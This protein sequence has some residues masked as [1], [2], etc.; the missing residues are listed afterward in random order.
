[1]TAVELVYFPVTGYLNAV[2][3]GVLAAINATVVFWPRV[4][5]GFTV[6]ISDLDLGSGDDQSAAVVFPPQSV[7]TIGGALSYSLLSNSSPIA[8]ALAAAVPPIAELIYDVEFT[9][10]TPGFKLNNFA[11]TASVDTTPVN[12][13][14]PSL[15][16]LPYLGP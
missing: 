7:P 1:M 8:T 13:T 4:P 10:V 16:Q 6:D 15:T 12:I 2:N 14:S 5:Y 9:Q 3:D 11:F